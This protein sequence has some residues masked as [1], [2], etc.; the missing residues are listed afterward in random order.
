[1]DDA[2]HTEV[3]SRRWHV[4]GLL[5][6]GAAG[7]YAVATSLVLGL[8]RQN[9]PG[10]GLFPFIAATAVTTFSVLALAAVLL[11]TGDD[12]LPSGE[13]EGGLRHTILRVAVYLAALVFYAAVLDALGFIASTILVVVF[14]L[15]IA[16][17]YGWLTTVA[18]A[19]GTSA[20]CHILFVTA[21][22]A[23]LPTGH[24]WDRMFY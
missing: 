7:V 6:I 10:E 21:L 24:L 19:V 9:S 22:G 12:R 3:P 18:L 23:L 15:K 5:L 17:G 8:W 14:I 20:A 2:G 16:E 11:R 1:M 13:T 4:V